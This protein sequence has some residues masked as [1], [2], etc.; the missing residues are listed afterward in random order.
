METVS[1]SWTRE[2]SVEE[3]EIFH[4]SL[5][6]FT[7]VPGPGAEPPR[8]VMSI[9]N[10][11]NHDAESISSTDTSYAPSSAACSNNSSCSEINMDGDWDQGWVVAE[12]REGV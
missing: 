6:D 5:T 11:L 4:Q 10:V 1:E 2:L 3:A 9:E 12:P 8:H 7:G